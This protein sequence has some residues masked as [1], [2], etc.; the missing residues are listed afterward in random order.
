MT[1]IDKDALIK[2]L[3]EAID[4]FVPNDD[5]DSSFLQGVLTA[6]RIV[7]GAEEVKA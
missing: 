1:L 6:R 7:K 4:E 5:Y 2:E 3:D